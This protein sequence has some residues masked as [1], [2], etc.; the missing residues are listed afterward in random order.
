MIHVKLDGCNNAAFV[1]LTDMK[2]SIMIAFA[3]HS[4]VQV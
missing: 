3:W 2:D 1:Q 4:T